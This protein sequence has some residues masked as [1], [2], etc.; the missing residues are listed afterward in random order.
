MIDALVI[1]WKYIAFYRVRTATLVA[2]VA[3]IAALPLALQLLLEESEHQLMSRAQ[4]TPLLLGARGSALDLVMSSLYFSDDAPMPVTLAAAD[5]ID[6]SGLADAIPLYLGLT[7][8]GFP[9]VGTTI[10]YFSFRGLEISA[11]RLPL[12]LGEC[13]LGAEVAENLGVGPGD[14]LLTSPQAVFDLAGVYPL[15][16]KVSGVLAR[17]HGPDDR[18][19]LVD[20]KTAWVARGLVHGHDDLAAADSRDILRSDAGNIIAN[21]RL[22]QFNEVTEANIDR[23]HFHGDLSGFPLTAVLPVPRD[24]RSATILRG[25]YLDDSAAYQVSVPDTV[26]AGLLNTIFRIK[27]V[28]DGAIAVVGLATLLALVLVFSLSMRLRQRE[29]DTVFRIGG[30]RRVVF[31]LVVAEIVIILSL[32]AVVCAMIL[33][34]VDQYGPQLVRSLVLG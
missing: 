1:A 7:A 22:T 34:G 30:S 8:R 24:E 18:A 15:K 16:M 2:C 6:Q 20:L 25:R 5:V 28:L 32:G 29:L 27:Q 33:V 23:F 19:V 31:Q 11:G 17:S 21:A 13:V 4:S 10:D 26:I 14:S 12:R 9:V 3:L